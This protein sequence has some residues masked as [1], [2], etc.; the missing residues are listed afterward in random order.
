MASVLF[1]IGV[2]GFIGMALAIRE[3][4][5][6]MSVQQILFLRMG[7]GLLIL[8]TAVW[9]VRGRAGFRDF[10]TAN[11]PLHVLRNVFQMSGQACWIY[12]ISVLT[13]ATVFAIEYSSPL[14]AALMGS[15]VL[16]EH[17]TSWQ[18]WGLVLG[19]IGILVIVRPGGEAFSWAGLA[20]LTGSAAFGAHFLTSRIVGRYDAALA[21]PFWT[22]A[23]Q[24]PITLVLALTDWR[25]VGWEHAPM[26]LLL[27]GSGVVSQT[28]ISAAVKYAPLARVVPLDY[29]RLPIIAVIGVF[30]YQ[31]VLDP[32]AMAGAII[33]IGA[34]VLSQRR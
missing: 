27:A 19:F 7:P 6:T 30:F 14:F 10:R 25:P 4:S 8:V 24:A 23:M 12:A 16:R 28:C 33:V 21:N 15:I 34:V 2:M 29:L 18:R 3:L 20:M 9:L 22:C 31:E 13:L 32:I 26:I 11:L 5:Y 1:F 17:P